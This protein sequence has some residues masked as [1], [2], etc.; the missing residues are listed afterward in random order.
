MVTA[1]RS[2]PQGSKKETQMGLEQRL[3]EVLVDFRLAGLPKG[4]AKAMVNA[5]L[6]ELWAKESRS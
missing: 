1:T 4:E 5:Q 6:T 2:R 3:R